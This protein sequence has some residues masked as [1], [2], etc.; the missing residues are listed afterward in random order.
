MR[1]SI[2]AEAVGGSS[3]DLWLLNSDDECGRSLVSTVHVMVLHYN[4]YLEQELK[5]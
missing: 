4:H 2:D 1:L 3:T 5:I